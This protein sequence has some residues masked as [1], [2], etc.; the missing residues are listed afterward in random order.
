MDTAYEEGWIKLYRKII[1]H[2]I[3]KESRTLHLFIYL[4]LKAN[5]KQSRFLFNQKEITIER[6]QLITGI[7]QISRD[8]GLT[9]RQIRTRLVRL[10]KLGILT[11]KTTNKFSIITVC[12]YNYYQDTEGEERQGERQAS[13]KQT[14]TNKNNKNDKNNKN[15]NNRDTRNSEKLEGP[16]ELEDPAEKEF[17]SFWNGTFTRE[18]GQPYFFTGGKED[19]LVKSLLQIYSLETLKGLVR[20]FFQDEQCRRQGLTIQVF[21]REINRLISLKEL[22]PLAQAKRELGWSR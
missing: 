3:F 20:F 19:K 2:P 17:L 18:T 15:K 7:R 4:L 9:N 1:H 13:D 11:R 14:T 16:E 6:G 21:Y 22:D 5:H 12:N 10:E 8:T